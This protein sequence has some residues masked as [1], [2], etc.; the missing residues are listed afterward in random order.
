MTIAKRLP[1]CI[2]ALILCLSWTLGAA[3]GLSKK[4]TPEI[5]T[6]YEDLRPDYSAPSGPR[7]DLVP[8]GA[9]TENPASPE[10]LTGPDDTDT[11]LKT[12]DNRKTIG[13]PP[14][15]EPADTGTTAS[16]TGEP[17]TP[18]PENT[19]PPEDLTPDAPGMEKTSQPVAIPDEAAPEITEPPPAATATI[20]VSP[21]TATAPIAATETTPV[22]AA[23]DTA[24]VSAATD[25]TPVA[26]ATDTIEA[27][28]A[29]GT[30]ITPATGTID[31]ATDT[32]AAEP[33]TGTTTTAATDTVATTATA[34]TTTEEPET[35]GSTFSPQLGP[36][37]IYGFTELTAQDYSFSGN[38]YNFRAQNGLLFRDDKFRERISLTFSGEMENGVTMDGEFLE[39]P[40]LD[41][42][43]RLSAKGPRFTAQ[44]GDA[45]AR[46]QSGDMTKFS[47]SIRGLDFGYT[48]GKTELGILY[49]NQKS[50]TQG[51]T[52]QGRNIRGPY[53]LRA[54]SIVENS[55]VVR[56]NGQVIP[57]SQYVVD[58]FLGQITFTSTLDPSDTIEVTY[59]SALWYALNT[60]NLFGV[61]L[62]SKFFGDKLSLGLSQLSEETRRLPDAKIFSASASDTKEDLEDAATGA[63]VLDLGQTRLEKN[64]ELISVSDSGTTYLTRD[65]DYY[66]DYAQG[67][68]TFATGSA[69]FSA[70]SATATITVS[71]NYY[72]QSYFQWVEKEVLAGEGEIEYKLM[73]ERIYGGTEQ[74][75]LFESNAFV[76]TLVSG[77]DYEV[78]EGNNS[79][80]FLDPGA[81][82][83]D[84]YGRYVEVSYEVAPDED[85]WSIDE[86]GTRTV[87]SMFGEFNAGKV[88]LSGEAAETESDVRL[89]TVQ[90]T[91][92]LV[93][94][95][96]DPTQREYT[97]QNQALYN[98][99]EV[100]FDDTVGPS[101]R[102]R[103]GTDFVVE[104]DLAN[105]ATILNF[106]QDIPA[107]TTIIANYQYQQQATWLNNQSGRAL[108]FKANAQTGGSSLFA[109]YMRK[110][111]FFAPMTSYN[112]L[113]A[114]R[115]FARY[116]LADLH[117]FSLDLDYAHQEYN[118]ELWSDDM[119][120]TQDRIKARVGYSFGAGREA[121][122][123]LESFDRGDNLATTLTDNSLSGQRFDVKYRVDDHV[124]TSAYYETRDFTDNITDPLRKTADREVQRGGF[125]VGYTPTQQFRVKLA[126]GNSKL[127]SLPPPAYVNI[128][129]FAINTFSTQLNATYNPGDD[130]SVNVS[131]DSQSI[132]DTRED[133][134]DSKLEN[135][136]ADVLGQG[137]EH[138]LVK[139]WVA[140]FYRQ[141]RPD[142]Y[143]GDSRTDVATLRTT[144]NTGREILL[145]PSFT[146]TKSRIGTGSNTQDNT[147]GLRADYRQD[148]QQ[149]FRAAASY[150]S[151]SRSGENISTTAPYT[152]T[153]FHNKQT[154]VGFNF[155]YM[156]S[157]TMTWTGI[158]SNTSSATGSSSIQDRTNYTA[159][160]L[161]LLN[162]RATLR[163]S[164]TL[165]QNP[166]SQGDRTTIELGA[167]SK[168]DDHIDV[169]VEYKKQDQEKSTGDYS[170]TM[171]KL[172]VLVHF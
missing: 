93:A 162:E 79:I 121:A 52:F 91:G 96:S 167:V 21:A 11:E 86:T 74:V 56:V 114:E 76:R 42:V 155:D 164:Y 25:T 110:G 165:D 113:E 77:E 43:F 63:Y 27:P 31:I 123:T 135:I 81:I 152:V 99:V 35:T 117:N 71:Y 148:A 85:L 33:A 66:I 107:G 139:N 156:P 19:G 5:V 146:A 119:R 131:M 28:P 89:K 8:D 65:S 38:E 17:E 105:G 46:F 104:Q 45:T 61:S 143:Y 102:R 144:L 39:M 54:T 48:F 26:A 90:V 137:S 9:S 103:S 153:T 128:S 20:P 134:S 129:A 169:D 172:K 116:R 97:L 133:A 151:S 68:I 127:H 100:F 2:P 101:S 168:V 87:T 125:S 145:T 49:S 60:G 47:K 18:A 1:F 112:D 130:I 83:S 147:V 4:N 150:N 51:D 75:D 12:I 73:Y 115:M 159:R 16:E 92:E 142:N 29:T 69:T 55:E 15:T 98:T 58:Y 109:E 84:S 171:F 136:R 122:I 108:R 160:L 50:K 41:R 95:V 161:Y 40:Y 44:V 30:A 106:K 140:T 149:G 163:F 132:D 80:V 70:L 126:L 57:R 37:R 166:A 22:S 62:K 34:T 78:N 170:G 36:I 13:P 118:M 10:D 88:T 111:P 7:E 32:I 158:Y 138:G 24:P 53:I 6:G 3:Q 120:Q 59:E 67:V 72:D 94:F 157:P 141:D 14:G 154:Q 124:D 23:T 64:H 82:P